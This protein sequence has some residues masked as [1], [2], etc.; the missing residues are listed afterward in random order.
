MPTLIM[1]PV[2][3]SAQLHQE[4]LVRAVASDGAGGSTCGRG[5]GSARRCANSPTTRTGSTT[6]A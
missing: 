6:S 5:S 1:R 4:N 2:S 3:Q